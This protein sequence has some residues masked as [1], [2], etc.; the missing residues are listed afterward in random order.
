[1]ICLIPNIT[2]YDVGRPLVADVR[3]GSEADICAATGNVRFASD[4]DHESG[5]VPMVMSALTPKADMCSARDD[6]R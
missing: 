5:H 4:S 2:N 6:V 3:F 1:M